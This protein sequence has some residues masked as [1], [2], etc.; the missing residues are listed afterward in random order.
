MHIQKLV[1]YKNYAY[2]YAYSFFACLHIGL[3]NALSAVFFEGS[4]MDLWWQGCKKDC[5]Y[6]QKCE[7]IFLL[8]QQKCMA[9]PACKGSSAALIAFQDWLK[10]L[11]KKLEKE[12]ASTGCTCT[13]IA[14]TDDDDFYSPGP[15]DLD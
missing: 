2:I 10:G 5:P 13:V 15:D 8:R 12:A 9:A 7:E 14:T 11:E 3:Q 6:R 1:V 4:N